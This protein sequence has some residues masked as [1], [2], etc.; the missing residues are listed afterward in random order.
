MCI[1]DSICI[2]I[3][4]Y[5]KRLKCAQTWITQFYL[6]ITPCL[7]LLPSRGASPPFGWYSFTVPRTVEG[8]VDLGG[9][10]HTVIKCRLRESNPD[11]VTHPSTNRAQHRLTSLI[12]TNDAITTPRCH[13]R[14]PSTMNVSNSAI[15]SQQHEINQ[16]SVVKCSCWW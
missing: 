1:R 15:K 3:A 7:P 8:S 2:Y 12:E 9:G 13:L 14:T 10:L 6:Q 16:H 4:H 5:A 11:T